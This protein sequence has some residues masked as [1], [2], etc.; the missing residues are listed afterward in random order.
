VDLDWCRCTQ[1]VSRTKL[2]IRGKTM[3]CMSTNIAAPCS[4]WGTT[5]GWDR[6][7]NGTTTA[8]TQ[9]WTGL[10]AG[11]TYT[12]VVIYGNGGGDGTGEQELR[13]FFFG[14]PCS[15]NRNNYELELQCQ[16]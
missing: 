5:H 13:Q 4:H 16:T 12:G 11:T 14:L 15:D 10:T 2:V 3:F 6:P 8:A 1:P 7:C 9:T